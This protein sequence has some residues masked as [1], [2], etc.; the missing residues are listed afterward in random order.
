[1][2]LKSFHAPS[3]GEALTLVRDQW[4]ADAIVVQ[5][6]ES[7]GEG[8]IVVAAL[9][10]APHDADTFETDDE[11]AAD[12]PPGNPAA[13]VGQTL[14]FH[15]LP[16]ACRRRLLRALPDGVE[17][18]PALAAALNSVLTFAPLPV[19]GEQRVA[20]VGPPG[21]GKTLLAAKLAARAVLS[22]RRP[23][24]ISTDGTRAGGVEQL[25]AFTRILGV[26]MKVCVNAADLSTAVKAARNMPVLID[27]PGANPLIEA[28]LQRIAELVN[29]AGA[30]PVLVLPAGG[31]A[32][33]A[34]ETAQAF[35]RLGV[36]RLCA[37][38]LD[39]ARRYGAPIAAAEAAGLAL[40]EISF[41]P[42]VGQGLTAL[43]AEVLSRMLMPHAGISSLPLS[44]AEAL[45]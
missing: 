2:R 19:S 4:G 28:D 31:D 10:S 29:A 13:A 14:Q 11:A 1:M 40:G 38:R 43:S 17:V 23:R 12:D 30:V 20:L 26:E 45:P 37:T 16:A 32:F 39:L 24:V 22:G 9:E 3:L 35:A 42:F 18:L 5:T 33:E 8:A 7:P 44:L 41:S 15:G 21:A 34:A 36:S 25:A 6:E 27:T